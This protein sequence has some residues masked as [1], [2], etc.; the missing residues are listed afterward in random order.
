MILSARGLTKRFGGV[1]VA[2]DLDIDLKRG[3][4]VALIG[5]NGAGKTTLFNMLTGFVRPDNGTIEFDGRRIET[6]PSHRRAR[7]GLARTWQRPRLFDSLTL[8]DN[9]LIAERDYAGE[10]IAEL[11]LQ[12]GRAHV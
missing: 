5:P 6:L 4:V 2:E 12:I 10:R 11:M 3:E 7:L 8:L 9:L 1:V